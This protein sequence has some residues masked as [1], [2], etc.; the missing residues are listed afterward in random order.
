M[1]FLPCVMQQQKPL[2]NSYISGDRNVQPKLIVFRNVNIILETDL[3]QVY[4]NSKL[5]HGYL[6]S[7]ER[8]AYFYS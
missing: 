3:D 5:K 7:A 4:S 1:S 2:Y 8:E 6:K